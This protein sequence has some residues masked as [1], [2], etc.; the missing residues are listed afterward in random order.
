MQI[1]SDREKEA[2]GL[3][4]G[5]GRFSRQKLLAF[6]QAY[7]RHF[8]ELRNPTSELKV[9]Q[10]ARVFLYVRFQMIDGLPRLQ[11]ALVSELDQVLKQGA[12]FPQ[13]KARELTIA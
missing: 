8:G 5:F 4:E 12:L 13:V 9:A 10:P 2:F 3:G 7:R 11:M 6:G 1:A